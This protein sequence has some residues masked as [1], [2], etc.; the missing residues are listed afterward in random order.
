MKTNHTQRVSTSLSRRG[1]LLLETAMSILIIGIFGFVITH[2]SAGLIR[3]EIDLIERLK[4][5]MLAQSLLEEYKAFGSIPQP[6]PKNQYLLTW[7]KKLDRK[8]DTHLITVQVQRRIG[9]KFKSYSL[10]T[11]TNKNTT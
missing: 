10:Q 1:F 5:V 6:N 3:A 9:D 2:W 11:V 8:G 7:D 4:I